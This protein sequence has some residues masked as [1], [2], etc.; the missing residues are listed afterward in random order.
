MSPAYNGPLQQLRRNQ[1]CVGGKHNRKN[2]EES[3]EIECRGGEVQQQQGFSFIL[4]LSERG[5]QQSA[6]PRCLPTHTPPPQVCYVWSFRLSH[7]LPRSR[8]LHQRLWR[9]HQPSYS[10]LHRSSHSDPCSH[11]ATTPPAL[12]FKNNAAAFGGNRWRFY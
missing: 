6:R 4:Q 10:T 3:E 1:G 12:R 2:R 5:E 8:Y 11:P 9:S 7:S